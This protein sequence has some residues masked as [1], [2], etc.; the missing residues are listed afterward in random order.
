MSKHH[1]PNSGRKHSRQNTLFTLITLF[2][3]LFSFAGS[4]TAQ[5]VTYSTEAGQILKD[6]IPFEGR[7]VNAMHEFGGNSDDMQGLAG[8]W[9]TITV[10][11]ETM[12]HMDV[13]PLSGSAI[14][15]AGG[16]YIHALQGIVDKNRANGKVTVLVAMAWN[17]TKLTGMAPGSG[18]SWW[19]SFLTRWQAIANQF[20]NQPDV[21]FEVWNEPYNDSNFS[22]SAWLSTMGLLVDNIRATGA[23]N[24]IVVPGCRWGQSETVIKNQGWNL[25]HPAGQSA[26]NNIVFTLHA[27]EQWFGRFP[28]D[29]MYTQA[30]IETRIQSLLNSGFALMFSEYGIY[31]NGYLN[32]VD[33][34]LAACAKKRVSTMAWIWL[35]DGKAESL[36]TSTLQPNDSGTYTQSGQTLTYNHGYGTAVKNYLGQ[37]MTQ[38]QAI[39]VNFVGYGASLVSGNSVGVVP[40]SNWSNATGGTGTLNNLKDN[41]ATTTTAS[42]TWSAPAIGTTNVSGDANSSMMSG[43]LSAASTSTSASTYSLTLSNLPFASNG[44][45]YDVYLYVDGANGGTVYSATYTLS[46]SLTTPVTSMSNGATDNAVNYNGTFVRCASPTGIGNYI[47]FLNIPSSATSFTISATPQGTSG[48]RNTPINGLQIVSR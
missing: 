25:L 20:K 36:R 30:S 40:Y 24:L 33:N 44:N 16:Q 2:A 41:T 47:K 35:S 14:Q 46:S 22:E 38:P 27:Y 5:A 26:R 6:G 37:T 34:F 31:N 15:I 45:S 21:W 29:P 11:R 8:G 43:Y 28:N 13:Q 39:G 7:G 4:K 12:L 9:D 32:K 23:S 18:L 10:V 1:L 19:N 48:Y 42:V 17:G 3:F